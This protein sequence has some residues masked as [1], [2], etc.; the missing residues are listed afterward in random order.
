MQTQ[1]VFIA[2]TKSGLTIRPE[3]VNVLVVLVRH[4]IKDLEERL[5]HLQTE[6]AR[7]RAD[8][9]EGVPQEESIISDTQRLLEC[10]KAVAIEL[11]HLQNRLVQ[12]YERNYVIWAEEFRQVRIRL[13]LKRIEDSPHLMAMVGGVSKSLKAENHWFSSQK[14]INHINN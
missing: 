1:P 9:P 2:I 14:F 10:T 7:A 12:W 3:G 5:A 6:A 8:V 11:A 13:G 4:C